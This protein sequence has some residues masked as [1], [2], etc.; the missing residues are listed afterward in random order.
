MKMCNSVSYKSKLYIAYYILEIIEK[1]ATFTSYNLLL[2]ARHVL[3]ISNYII[4]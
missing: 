3:Y 2:Y 1:Y 4:I